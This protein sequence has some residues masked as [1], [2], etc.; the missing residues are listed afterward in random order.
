MDD[1]K[2]LND[3][4]YKRLNDNKTALDE[5]DQPSDSGRVAPQQ[6]FEFIVQGILITCVCGL[7]LLANVICIIVM[8]RPALKKGRCASVSALLIAMAGVDVILL[9]CR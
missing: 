9:I 5:S 8:N 2:G 4:P 1:E 3:E 7:G 6:Y